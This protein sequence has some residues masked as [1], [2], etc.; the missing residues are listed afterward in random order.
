MTH[1]DEERRKMLTGLGL[2]PDAPAL[3]K[4]AKKKSKAVQTQASTD[5]FPL[6]PPGVDPHTMPVDDIVLD[7]RLLDNFTDLAFSADGNEASRYIFKLYKSPHKNTERHGAL[8]R[9][10]TSF[11]T[12][13]RRNRATGGMVKEKI[14]STKEQR[15]IAAV[16]ASNGLTAA[17]VAAM[18]TKQVD[19]DD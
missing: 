17:D 10:I 13:E 5:E 4:P 3:G 11:I 12:Q 6:A 9:K 15:D 14:A 1:T 19:V 7:A 16:L 2:N 18:L 8:Q